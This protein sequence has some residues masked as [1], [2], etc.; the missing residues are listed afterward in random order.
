MCKFVQI[1]SLDNQTLRC[2]P[3]AE[4]LFVKYFKYIQDDFSRVN[5]IYEYICSLAPFFWVILDYDDNFMGFVYLDNIVGNSGRMYSA[6]LTTA[7]VPAA[8]GN[9]TRYSAKIFLKKCFDELGLQKITANIYPDNLR[10]KNL[11]KDA[12]FLYE[13]TLKNATLRFGKM[14]DIDVYAIYRSYY[15]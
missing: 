9:F 1:V 8:W 13:S 7:F 12:G 4:K 15:F 11:L 10:V 6:E 5:D 3:K 2:I 14:Q